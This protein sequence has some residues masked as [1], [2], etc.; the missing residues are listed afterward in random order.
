M[1]ELLYY[2]LVLNISVYEHTDKARYKAAFV[3]Q[4]KDEGCKVVNC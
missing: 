3:S 4:A 2:A 1:S